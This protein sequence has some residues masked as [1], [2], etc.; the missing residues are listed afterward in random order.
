MNEL[1]VRVSRVGM[2]KRVEFINEEF[3]SE[4]TS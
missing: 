3:L 2:E 1:V 4:T